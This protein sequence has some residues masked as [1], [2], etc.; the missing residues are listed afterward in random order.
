M[1][2]N[3]KAIKAMIKEIESDITPEKRSQLNHIV[4][5]LEELEAESAS[6]S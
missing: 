3:I 6:L 4:A 5:M 1:N 2:E